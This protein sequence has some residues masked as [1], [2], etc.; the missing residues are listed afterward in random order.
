MSKSRSGSL[1]ELITN[2]FSC[3]DDSFC[4]TRS[5]PSPTLLIFTIVY[6]SDGFSC[7]W[8]VLMHIVVSNNSNFHLILPFSKTSTR[9]E[10]PAMCHLSLE[11]KKVLRI[12]IPSYL[13]K[14]DRV[15]QKP[16]S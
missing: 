5:S 12:S 6:P 8:G 11:M 13:A 7:P 3:S 1:R 15:Q 2:G 9:P 16:D 14:I 4:S 10:D